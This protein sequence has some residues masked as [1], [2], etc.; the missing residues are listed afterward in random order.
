MIVL[1]QSLLLAQPF[2]CAQ[3]APGCRRHPV[4]EA[5]A[6]AQAAASPGADCSSPALLDALTDLT[7]LLNDDKDAGTLAR[8][9]AAPPP[10]ARR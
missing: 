10:H 6:R 9:G 5:L 3:V 2:H 8:T 1:S 7:S 4:T